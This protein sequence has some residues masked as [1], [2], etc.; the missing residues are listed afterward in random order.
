MSTKKELQVFIIERDRLTDAIRI[1]E[2]KY[3][4]REVSKE[5]YRFLRERYEG[6]L[7]E[8]E[9]KLGMTKAEA[10]RVRE[11]EKVARPLRRPERAPP[12]REGAPL[13]GWFGITS[14][15]NLRG[16][17]AKDR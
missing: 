13:L 1:L 14:P 9:Q 6:K 3:R 7:K 12:R 5:D 10:K 17:A 2:E 4:S 16:T 11:R 8:V 15:F